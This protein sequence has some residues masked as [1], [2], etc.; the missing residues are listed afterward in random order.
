MPVATDI[1]FA[2]GCLSLVRGR[3]PASIFVFLTALAI[4]DDLGAIAVIALFYGGVVDLTS[5]GL[6]L[7][8]TAVLFLLG[9]SGSR[10]RGGY[11]RGRRRRSR[12]NGR[13][14]GS[15]NH[16]GRLWSLCRSRAA[17]SRHEASGEQ[18]E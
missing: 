17:S 8:L 14:N 6:A 12:R 4:F 16:P 2:L 7:G 13:R 15:R 3:V 1:A 11:G 10:W 9:R 5:L 18:A